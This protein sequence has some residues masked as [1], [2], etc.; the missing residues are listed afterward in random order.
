MN[1]MAIS[2][3]LSVL[4]QFRGKALWTALAVLLDGEGCISILKNNRPAPLLVQYS[5]NLN[6]TNTNGEWL[7]AWRQR[8][9]KGNLFTLEQPKERN[10]KARYNWIVA[11]KASVV[12]IL[13][14]IQPYLICKREQA[15]VA[16]DFIQNKVVLPFGERNHVRPS[17]LE[18]TRREEL[19]NRMRQLNKKGRRES[20]ET[21]RQD[22]RTGC[23]IVRSPEQPGAQDAN[24]LA[25]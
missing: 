10:W 3:N 11:D 14:K 13:K 4:R 2:E 7:E 24:V 6:F 20:V 21:I 18:L 9:E 19:Y 16:I 5:V 15:Q 22:P 23:D 17:E 12:Y 8:L 25:E 1:N